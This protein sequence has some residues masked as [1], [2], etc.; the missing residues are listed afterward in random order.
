MAANGVVYS[1]VRIESIPHV[2]LAQGWAGDALKD[3]VIMAGLVKALDRANE[4]GTS[5]RCSSLSGEAIERII[6]SVL[7]FCRKRKTGGLVWALTRDERPETEAMTRRFL[8][9]F[10]V[11]LKSRKK[12]GKNLIILNIIYWKAG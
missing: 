1:G 8:E 7:K 5:G 11:F 6:E 10:T 2:E 12:S 3:P 9:A 4:K